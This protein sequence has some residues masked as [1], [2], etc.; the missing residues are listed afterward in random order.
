MGITEL[1]QSTV[2]HRYLLT[3][4]SNCTA[5]QR[6]QPLQSRRQRQPVGQRSR[7]PASGVRSGRG[8]ASSAA[9]ATQA[10][11]Q[12]R[13]ATAA[14]RDGRRGRGRSPDPR[15][16]PV[17]EAA[18][19]PTPAPAVTER[20][21]RHTRSRSQ[22]KGPPR[23]PGRLPWLSSRPAATCC[24]PPS[25]TASSRPRTGSPASPAFCSG[26]PAL[27]AGLAPHRGRVAGERLQ[28]RGEL[29]MPSPP[30]PVPT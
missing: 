8:Q 24:R 12:R 19:P 9:P 26:D 16:V 21:G 22:D 18:W 14:G 15:S 6:Q 27:L 30:E 20:H 28:L 3:L 5:L 29:T 2:S 25:W 13:P 17:G 10:R 7:P 4:P 11:A 1:A 23:Q